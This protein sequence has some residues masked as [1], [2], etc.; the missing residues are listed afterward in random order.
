M[1]LSDMLVYLLIDNMHIISSRIWII[2]EA[3]EF[4]NDCSNFRSHF[5]VKFKSYDYENLKLA[6]KMI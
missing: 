6:K 1:K 2:R 4:E 5:K 3:T